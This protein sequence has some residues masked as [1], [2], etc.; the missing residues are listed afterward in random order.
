[1]KI[2]IFLLAILIFIGGNLFGQNEKRDTTRI[3]KLEEVII[4]ANRLPVMLKSNPG[5]IS[6][7]TS[8]VLSLMPKAA[9]VE[10][11]LRLVPGVRIDNQH[12]GERVHVSIRGQG[13]LTERGMRGIGVIIDGIPVN[14]PSGFA[15]DLYDVDW[16]TVKK[17]EVMRGPAAG[18]YGGGGAA[19]ILNITTKDGGPKPVGGELSQTIGS[20]GYSKLNCMKKLISIQVRNCQSP[21]FSR[22]PIIFSKILKG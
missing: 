1:M 16:G 13:I 18:L 9:A 8:D 4:T 6:V 14:D 7:V 20:N 19:G 22:A 21:R 15:P 10:E 12:D 5:S 3:I 2:N 17:V 11:A